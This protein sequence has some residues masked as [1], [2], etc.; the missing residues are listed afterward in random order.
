RAKALDAPRQRAGVLVELARFHES[1][2]D[3][4]A[5]REAWTDAITND[6]SNEAAASVMLDA[7]TR[8]ERWADAAPLCELVVNAAIRDKDT[9]SLFTR[10]RLQTRISAA[11]GDP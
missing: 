9:E 4:R 10:L 11:L 7:Y 6:P 8:E 3:A 1:R 2:G 5:A